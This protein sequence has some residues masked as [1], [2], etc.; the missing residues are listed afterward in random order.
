MHEKM[1]LEGLRSA[2]AEQKARLK[3]LQEKPAAP[4]AADV[5]ALIETFADPLAWAVL[6]EGEQRQVYH[7]LVKKVVIKRDREMMVTLLL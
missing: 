7:S 1:P 2:I 3:A 5:E 4:Q 6:S